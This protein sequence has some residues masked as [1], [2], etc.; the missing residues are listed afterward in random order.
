MDLAKA[1][2]TK[3]NSANYLVWATQVEALLQ[4]RGLWKHIDG[5]TLG[6]AATDE[7][8]EQTANERSAARATIL[9]TIDS[10]YILLIPGESN[11]K[12]MWENLAD[13]NMPKCKASVHTLRNRLKNIT[14]SSSD[15]VREYVN[16]SARLNDNCRTLERHSMTMIRSTNC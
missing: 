7:E 1:A 14:M 12:R 5:F 4:V 3:L 13:A 6:A 9:C 8:R 11:P 10:E 16:K 15:T 2:I